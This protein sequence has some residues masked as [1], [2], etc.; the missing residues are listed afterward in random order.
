MNMNLIEFLKQYYPIITVLG[1]FGALTG[2]FL[3]LDTEDVEFKQYV[4]LLS[5][6]LFIVTGIA[7]LNTMPESDDDLLNVFG[8]LLF[9]LII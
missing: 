9:F 4:S 6:L 3:E 7:L 1:V 5:F 8:V 2:F